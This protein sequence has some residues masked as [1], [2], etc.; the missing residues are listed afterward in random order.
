M[1]KEILFVLSVV[2]ALFLVQGALAITFDKTIVSDVIIKEFNQ[3]AHF[4]LN[5]GQVPEGD[6][7]LYTLTDVSL[8]PKDSFYLNSGSNNLDVYVYQTSQLNVAGYYTFTYGLKKFGGETSEDTMMVKLVSLKDAVEISSDTIDPNS[9]EIKFY[10]ENREK[11]QLSNITAHFTSVF[12]DVNKNFDLS[13]LGKAEFSVTIDAEK[14]KTIKAGV[15]VVKGEFQTDKG[16]KTVEGKIYLGEKKDIRTEEDKTGFLIYTDTVTKTNTGNVPQDVSII[17]KKN[18]ITRL[19]TSFNT[20]PD[21]VTRNGL[22]ISYMWN[23]ALDPADTITIKTKTNYLFPLIIILFALVIIFVF[24]RYME[25][26]LEVKK[27]VSTVK[28]KGG[29]FA[30]RVSIRVKAKRNVENVSL[31]D[32]IP[33]LVKI[34]ESFGLVKP[35]KVDAANR[36]IHWDLGS[37]QS[38]E[39]RI[40]SYIIYSKI[41]VV[42]KFSLP[43][44]LAVFEQDGKIHEIESN[45]VFFLAEQVS[46]DD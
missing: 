38:G 29:E 33:S 21:A 9:N 17:V 40:V 28:A 42:G 12:F 45:S 25:T 1:K 36:R 4:V 20:V 27:S 14:I 15:Y 39:E 7:Q 18:I 3:P 44:S 32:R 13:P 34:Y 8:F 19:F 26:K 10:V 31:V 37:M 24:K 35:S 30:L 23:K 2:L 41:G 43:P 11:A 22:V 46:R 5:L 6:Y 16:V